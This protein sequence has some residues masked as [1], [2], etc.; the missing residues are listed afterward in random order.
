M[1]DPE[2]TRAVIASPIKGLTTL[3]PTIDGLGLRERIM[4][5]KAA[6][7]FLPSLLSPF[8]VSLPPH[9]E[10]DSNTNA[11]LAASQNHPVRGR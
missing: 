10:G 1:R 4:R 2:T 6:R 11:N 5:E 8:V 7:C 9:T 3:S